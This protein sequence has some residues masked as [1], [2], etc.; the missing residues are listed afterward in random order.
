MNIIGTIN[1]RGSLA[2]EYQRRS[3]SGQ[4][5]CGLAVVREGIFGLCG[6][7]T[8]VTYSPEYYV[9]GVGDWKDV[10]AI[11]GG[12]SLVMALHQDGHVSAALAR[13]KTAETLAVTEG[14]ENIVAIATDGRI[15]AGKAA[16]ETVY[17]VVIEIK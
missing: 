1:E 10:T 3:E 9:S 16:D 8:V 6:D 13:G 15:A 5:F 7:G 2:R 14:W 12:G 11:R 17:I 4:K